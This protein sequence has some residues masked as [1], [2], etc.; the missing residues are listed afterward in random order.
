M[1]SRTNLLAT[2][3]ATI[4]GVLGGFLLWGIIADPILNDYMGTAT[5]VMRETPDFLYVVLGSLF[6]AFAFSTIYS[7]WARGKHSL[8][9]GA[10]Y[11]LWMGIFVGFGDRLIEF[12]VSNL[13]DITGT[14][15]NGI[16]YVIFFLV[17]GLIVSL[18]YGK[19]SKK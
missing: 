5:G 7:K 15:F 10:K 1:F 2:L 16:I 3:A 14:V 17:M 12:G 13:L 19:L 4:W 9:N 6:T 18:V 8:S 11:G